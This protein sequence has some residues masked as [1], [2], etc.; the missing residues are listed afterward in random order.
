MNKD[1]KLWYRQPA[2]KWEETLPIG[3]GRMGAMVFGGVKE[4]RLGLNEDSLWSGYYY[5]KNNPEAYSHLASVREKLFAGEYEA[6]E[7]EIRDGMLGEHTESYLPLGDLLI[8][9][10]HADEAE[11][12]TRALDLHTAVSSVEYTAGGVHFNREY[13]AS[14][15]HQAILLRLTSSKPAGFSVSFA[16]QLMHV[17]FAFGKEIQI[18]GKCPE[19]INQFIEEEPILRQGTRGKEFT[20]AVKILSTDGE[21]SVLEDRALRIENAT[22]TVLLFEAVK[23]AALPSLAGYEQLKAAHVADY[24]SIF[25]TCS[26]DLGEGPDL[27]TDE[28]LTALREG[29][30]DPALFAL[31]FA[32]GRYLLIASSREGSQ[33]ANLQGIWSWQLKAPWSS[34]FTTNI[35]TEMNYWPALSCNLVPCLEPYNRFMERLC[36]EGKKTARINYHARGFVHH[37]NADYWGNT[38]PVGHPQGRYAARPQSVRWGMWP[39]GGAWLCEELFYEYEYL[40]DETFLREVAY[41]IT[42]EAAL[43]LLDWVVEHNGEYVTA[44]STSPENSFITPRGNICPV[45]ISSAMDLSI[46]RELWG[47]Y[48]RMCEALGLENDEVL[49]EINEK[50]PRLAPIKTGS[51]GQVLE[52]HEELPENEPGHRHI[53]HLYGLFP[54]ELFANDPAMQEACRISLMHRLENGGGHTGWSCAWII[55]V[56]AILGD[57]ENAEKYLNVLLKRSTCDNLWDMHPPFQIDGNFGGIAGIANMLVQD[58]GGEVRFLP[59][60]PKSWKNGSVRGLRIK[61]GKTVDLTWKDGKLTEKVIHEPAENGR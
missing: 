37:H 43:F 14:F 23:P 4:E 3:N 36:E 21:V 50:L 13:F 6:A 29:A 41:P 45:G 32:Y 27:P 34:N 38:N 61:D 35:N 58:R 2:R 31:Y 1:L 56:F 54:A 26:L 22:E 47:N 19:H 9:M 57:A 28:R 46:I 10:D 44:P 42:R 11:A 15:P 24:R 55:N 17:A 8:H 5:D 51:Y 30:E 18:T 20:A 52:Y 48:A 16:S 12:Y 60:L 49:A 40:K 39:M 25:E 33:P 7:E 53:S 59:A